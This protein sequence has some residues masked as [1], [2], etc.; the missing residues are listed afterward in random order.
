MER[1]ER[2]FYF[3]LARELGMTVAELLSRISS[4]ELT[5]WAGLYELERRERERA[6]Q[7]QPAPPPKR[8]RR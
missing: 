7:S 2:R 6:A 5:E 4:A 1:P 8:K 3:D